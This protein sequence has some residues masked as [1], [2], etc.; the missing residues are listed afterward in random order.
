MF[1]YKNS[2]LHQTSCELVLSHVDTYYRPIHA[3]SSDSSHIKSS[4]AQVKHKAMK[5]E[6]SIQIPS[7]DFIVRHAPIS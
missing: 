7:I 4:T 5:G 1:E 3:N 2:V 6:S